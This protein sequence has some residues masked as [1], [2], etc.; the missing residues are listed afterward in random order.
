[1][2]LYQQFV[3]MAKKHSK[4]MA[5][6]DRTTE[7]NITYSTALIA[8]LIL[9]SKF[10]KYNKGFTGIM[11]PTSAGCALATLGVLMS[12]RTPVMINYSTG[13]ESN[14]LY[15]QKKCGFK[16]IITSKA[17]LEKINCPVIDG[18]V[19]L[20]DIMKE[21]TVFEKIK[22]LLKSKLPAKQ[23]LKLIHGGTI[24]E[25]AVVLFTSGSEKDPKAVELSHKN[26]SSNIENFG[27]YININSSDIL[28]ANLVFFHVFGLTVN[29][30]VPFYYGMTMVTYANP[31]DFQTICKIAREEKP[32]VM[33]G[34]PSFFWGYLHKSEPGDFKTLRIM[35]SGADKCPDALRDG[36][37]KKHGVTLLEGY[38]ATETSPVIS[39]NSHEYNRPGSTGRVIPN[40]QVRIE[41][42]E[43]GEECKKGD[44][45]KILVKGDSVMKG[46]YGDP[47]LT[48]EAVV[49]GWYNTG[50]MGYLDED[51]YLWHSGRFKRFVKIGGEMVSLVK[52][53]NTLEKFL[54]TGVSCCVVDV[55]DELRGSSIIATVSIEV[56]KND[57]L[58]KMGK[59]LPNIALPRDFIVIR[60]LPMMSTGK[61]DFR[62]VSRIVQELMN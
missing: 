42:F 62:T 18:M 32:T 30:W 48:A 31:L 52:V 1:M 41:N 35:V 38:G 39:V 58:K 50:D 61:I 14:A 4:K 7:K 9:T 11:V 53:E 40:L 25:T 57:I 26:I 6:I 34:T 13:A 10:K 37:M 17:L 46:Y 43:T 15:A 45:G 5:I 36:F 47:Q 44:V 60:D 59:E 24:D 33:V 20:E 49:D 54:P 12:G 19:M 21:V 22:A 8:S 28:L 56:N 3:T 27:N 16:T 2:L 29:L 55:S 23:I 51:N